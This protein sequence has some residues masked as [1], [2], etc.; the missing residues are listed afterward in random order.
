MCIP[1]SFAF[2]FVANNALSIPFFFLDSFLLPLPWVDFEP[3]FLIVCVF[4]CAQ[5]KP[6]FNIRLICIIVYF[7]S[8]STAAHQQPGRQH[9]DMNRKKT[10][11]FRFRFLSNFFLYLGLSADACEFGRNKR[12]GEAGQEN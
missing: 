7:C 10:M 6:I 4:L 5:T 11:I 2:A 9:P 1:S 3:L 12:W 8:G